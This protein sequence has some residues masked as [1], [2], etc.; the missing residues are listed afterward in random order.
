MKKKTI[1]IIIAAVVISL[2]LVGGTVFSFKEI[3]VINPFSSGIGEKLWKK[4]VK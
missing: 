1:T 3:S 2:I 4:K